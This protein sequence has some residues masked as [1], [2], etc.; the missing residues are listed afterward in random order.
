M[1]RFLLEQVLSATADYYEVDIESFA[2]KRS[3]HVSRDVAA[4][5]GRRLTTA[6][7]REMSESFGL[8][9]PDSVRALINRAEAAIETSSSLN[10]DVQT[11][12]SRIQQ[13]T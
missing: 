13:M 3:R 4:W 7:L 8:G 9:H 6:T 11:L 5:L 12:K 2:A 1:R 10:R